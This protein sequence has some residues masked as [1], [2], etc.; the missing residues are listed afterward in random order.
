M[1]CTRALCAVPKGSARDHVNNGWRPMRL[2]GARH[3]S[4]TP[5]AANANIPHVLSVARRGKAYGLQARRP[6]TPSPSAMSVSGNKRSNDRHHDPAGLVCARARETPPARL[7]QRLKVL[8]AMKRKDQL[9][10]KFKGLEIT[11]IDEENYN[12]V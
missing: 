2:I 1:M 5:S 3:V 4:S 10:E 7:H 8:L 12:K 6:P 9:Q 11:D